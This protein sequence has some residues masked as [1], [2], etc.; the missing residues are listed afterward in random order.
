MAKRN[1]FNVKQKRL[2]K[3]VNVILNCAIR[4]AK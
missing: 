3:P 2:I 4:G 1:N